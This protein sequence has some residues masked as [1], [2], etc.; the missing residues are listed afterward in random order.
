[1]S[2][3]RK[4]LRYKRDIF[5]FN[6][7]P[8][9]HLAEPKPQAGRICAACGRSQAQSQRPAHECCFFATDNPDLAGRC[10]AMY[11]HPNGD[12][13]RPDRSSVAVQDAH[14]PHQPMEGMER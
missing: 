14:R 4:K 6:R 1:M 11:L 13:A 12:G 5:I 2:Y 10:P 7:L 3:Q 9:L 8:A